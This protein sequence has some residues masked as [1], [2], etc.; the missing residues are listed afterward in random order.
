[1]TP[2]SSLLREQSTDSPGGVVNTNA[3]H[4]F[5]LGVEISALLQHYPAR[6]ISRRT[7]FHVYL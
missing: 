7:V 2:A 4:L 5:Y 3:P 1:M 6:H